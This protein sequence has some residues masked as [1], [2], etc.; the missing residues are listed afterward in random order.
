[1]RDFSPPSLVL[2]G[3]PA[4]NSDHYA[5]PVGMIDLIDPA[6]LVVN[7]NGW[8]KVKKRTELDY[9]FV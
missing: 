9:V 2:E 5:G 8:R 3:I 6:L 7:E 4:L 1:M